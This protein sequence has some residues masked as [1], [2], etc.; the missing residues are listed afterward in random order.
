MPPPETGSEETLGKVAE[1][2]PALKV[3]ERALAAMREQGFD[4]ASGTLV[5]QH[6]LGCG[7]TGYRITFRDI[8]PDDFSLVS[9]AGGV[10][11]ALDSYARQHLDGAIIDFDENP[12]SE[13]FWLDHP[14]A[15]F[16]AFC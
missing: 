13:G 2:V 7:G 14:D 16:A 4:P 12:E 5:I 9:S 1:A 15:A 11:T 8:A 6:V 10:T 3:T